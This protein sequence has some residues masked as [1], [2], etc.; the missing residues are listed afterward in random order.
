M[1]FIDKNTEIN[2][3]D[4]VVTSGLSGEHSAFPKGVHIGYI[5]DVKKDDSGLYQYAELAPSATVSLLDYVF[6]VSTGTREDAP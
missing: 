5:T 6:V 3:G 4:E 1:D 2:V